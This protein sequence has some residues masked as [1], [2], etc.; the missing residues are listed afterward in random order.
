MIFSASVA[1]I[2]LI[3]WSESDRTDNPRLRGVWRVSE[4]QLRTRKLESTRRRQ[5][6]PPAATYSRDMS[7]YAEKSLSLRDDKWVLNFNNSISAVCF[8]W[9][10]N[11]ICLFLIML[12][13]FRSLKLF[14]QTCYSQNIQFKLI[15]H[16]SNPFSSVYLDEK[17]N[18]TDQHMTHIN[19]N[20]LWL[21]D[22]KFLPYS[23]V[24][25]II[26][27]LFLI[28]PISSRRYPPIVDWRFI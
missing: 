8:S 24:A 10:H 6:S 13:S 9:V 14:P 11:K 5:L 12:I 22:D 2:N 23:T 19:T 21:P 18:S 15:I 4:F 20:A 17:F 25:K 28:L 27:Y 26:S 7:R 1:A 16:D 3:H